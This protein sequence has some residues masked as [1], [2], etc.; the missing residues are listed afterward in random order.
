MDI[1][2]FRIYGLWPGSAGR[3]S[4][5]NE[6]LQIADR[7]VCDW[8]MCTFYESSDDGMVYRTRKVPFFSLPTKEKGLLRKLCS[9]LSFLFLF[10]Y[11]KWSFPCWLDDY[12]RQTWRLLPVS[13]QSMLMRQEL[14][15]PPHP[16]E[17]RKTNLHPVRTFAAWVYIADCEKEGS[18]IQSKKKGVPSLSFTRRSRNS[19]ILILLVYVD[20]DIILTGL[21]TKFL[22]CLFTLRLYFRPFFLTARVRIVSVFY[23]E[24][25]LAPC[26]FPVAW[27]QSLRSISFFSSPWKS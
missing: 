9:T 7:G 12:Y 5:P 27:A 1:S 14:F 4:W 13:G 3:W 22:S 6:F 10:H 17:R 21:F 2:S 11:A 26:F 25:C 18:I 20:D 16:K 15:P 23:V 24:V 19:H 8:Y